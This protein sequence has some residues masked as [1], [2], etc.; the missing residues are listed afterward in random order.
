MYLLGEFQSYSA[1]SSQKPQTYPKL[2]IRNFYLES[3]RDISHDIQEREDQ[4][5]TNK[6]GMRMFSYIAH[7][8]NSIKKESNLVEKISL[9]QKLHFIDM[10]KFTSIICLHS[11][12]QWEV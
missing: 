7:L 2:D 12:S 9:K 8:R 1:L 10:D 3:Q 11:L 5:R 6:A 4:R